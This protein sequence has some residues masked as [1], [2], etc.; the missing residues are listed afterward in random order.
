M[1][2]PSMLL[3]RK[4]ESENHEQATA[5]IAQLTAVGRDTATPDLRGNSTFIDRIISP[6][7]CSRE[8]HHMQHPSCKSPAKGAQPRGA[9]ANAAAASV[10]I[11][12][13]TISNVMSSQLGVVVG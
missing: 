10:Q 5:M 11:T 12:P 2:S 9:P 8:C 7:V 13:N 4:R 3:W 6:P 1:L